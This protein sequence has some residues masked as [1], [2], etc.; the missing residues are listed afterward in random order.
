MQRALELAA[1]GSGWVAPNPMVGSVIVHNNRIIGEGWHQQCGGPHAEVNA[2]N[3]V[4]E[5]DRTLLP[6]ST[7]YVTLEPCSHFGKTPPCADLI[8][9]TNFKQVVVAVLDPNPLVAGR[10]V[11]R[12]KDSGIDVATGILTAQATELNKRFFTIHHQKRPYIVLKWAQ[13]SD[14]YFTKNNKQQHWITG[15]EARKLVHKWRSEEAAIMVGTQTLLADNPKLDVRLWPGGHQPLRVSFDKTGE[16]SEDMCLLDGSI[17][18]LIFTGV[19]KHTNSK[20]I[21]YKLIDCNR[22]TIEQALR[23]LFEMNIQSV[24]VEGGAKLLAAFIKQGLW[25]EARVFIGTATWGAGVKAPVLSQ[26]PSH[27]MQI[28]TDQLQYFKNI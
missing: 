5:N 6:E 21:Q 9:K 18:T 7:I 12:I 13:T 24:F 23:V 22:N 14:G 3:S 4:S 27:I 28:G 8:V 25:D 19:D 1:N 10:G 26:A 11:Q 2:I 15:T 20:N 17:P 16:L